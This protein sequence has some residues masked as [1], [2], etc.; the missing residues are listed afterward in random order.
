MT[1]SVR[2]TAQK[3]M[4]VWGAYLCKHPSLLNSQF[5]LHRSALI[6]PDA[7]IAVLDIQAIPFKANEVEGKLMR[8]PG[9]PTEED[10]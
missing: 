4:K 6:D 7:M 8:T 5:L 10:H 2:E 1:A 3:V 9:F